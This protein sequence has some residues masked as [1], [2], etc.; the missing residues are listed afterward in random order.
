MCWKISSLCWQ[1]RNSH[2]FRIH[3]YK[4]SCWR[5]L[6]KNQMGGENPL[7]VIHYS[8]MILPLVISNSS[9][10]L[11]PTPMPGHSISNANNLTLTWCT[12]CGEHGHQSM[13]IQ[14][15]ID[16]TQSQAVEADWKILFLAWQSCVKCVIP[17][18]QVKF[19][20]LQAS[21]FLIQPS[22]HI[23]SGKKKNPPLFFTSLTD[24]SKYFS[25]T[26][27]IEG[28]SLLW[29][30]EHV[31]S[32]RMISSVEKKIEWGFTALENACG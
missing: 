24:G 13:F 29:S 12:P 30:K 20:N 25:G 31:L 2:G 28:M 4:I 15:E 32:R 19:L 17:A 27:G 16:Q 23:N 7:S 22:L 18:G 3:Y 11:N 6:I 9:E 1:F 21:F 10:E 8:E 14:C 26:D 5:M